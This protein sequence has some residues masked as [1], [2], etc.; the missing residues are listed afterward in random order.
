MTETL[1]VIPPHAFNEL[2]DLIIERRDKL[3]RRLA[4]VAAYTIEFPDDVAFGTVSSIAERAAVQPS[5]L[6]RFAKALGYRG[7]SEMQALFQLRLRDRPNNYEARLDALDA[8]T[9]GHS[10]AMAV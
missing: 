10:P 6:V 8:H 4:Q 1:A 2:R 9:S 7:F 5:T 3:P